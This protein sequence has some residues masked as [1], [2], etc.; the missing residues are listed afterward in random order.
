MLE[1]I[2]I[3]KVANQGMTKPLLCKGSG[4]KTY[5]V[6][7]KRATGTGLIKEWMVANNGIFCFLICDA[8]QQR[9]TLEAQGSIWSKWR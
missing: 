7:G 9:L 5:Y 4:R 1:I 2:E 6:K 8:T 3:Q